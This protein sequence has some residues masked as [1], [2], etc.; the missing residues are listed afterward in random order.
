MVLNINLAEI[1][2]HIVKFLSTLR[3]D[4]LY[5]KWLNFTCLASSHPFRQEIFKFKSVYSLWILG[6]LVK[7]TDIVKI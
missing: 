1:Y 7:V 5:S 6:T 4:V 2:A 3:C